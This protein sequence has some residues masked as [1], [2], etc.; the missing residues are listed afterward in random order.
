MLI[1]G[2]TQEDVIRKMANNRKQM[3]A[4][5]AFVKN[6]DAPDVSQLLA[7]VHAM[8]ALWAME[9]ALRRWPLFAQIDELEPGL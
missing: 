2:G 5:T 7:R 3:D 6:Y 9:D 8:R 1:E 4:A